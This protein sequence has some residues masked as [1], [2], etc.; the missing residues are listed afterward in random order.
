MHPTKFSIDAA[1]LEAEIFLKQHK[2]S[3]I[4]RRLSRIRKSVFHPT[5]QSKL[6]SILHRNF[7]LP[8]MISLFTYS[9][10]SVN[11]T[12]YIFSLYSNILK[13]VRKKKKKKHLKRKNVID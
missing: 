8:T 7:S 12:K 2:M 4:D 6:L 3:V 10:S 5:K 11:D 1:D 9:A 13:L